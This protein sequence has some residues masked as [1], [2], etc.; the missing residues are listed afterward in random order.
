[1]LAPAKSF[2]TGHLA[3]RYIGGPLM[4]GIA[5]TDG[6]SNIMQSAGTAINRAVAGANR[7]AAVVASAST[8]DSSDVLAAL[9]DSRQ[10]CY[11]ASRRKADRNGQSV[12][13]FATRYSGLSSPQPS[14]AVYL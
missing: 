2:T 11:T 13:G 3:I 12:D 1:M 7:D 4:N 9:I 6:V 5:M 14:L 10:Q 8:V